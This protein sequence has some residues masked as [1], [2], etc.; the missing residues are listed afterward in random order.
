MHQHQHGPSVGFFSPLGLWAAGSNS[1][2]LLFTL[3]ENK[4]TVTCASVTVTHACVTAA[5]QTPAACVRRLM[6]LEQKFNLH[7]MLNADK[8]FLAQKSAPHRDFY[9]VRKVSGV[10]L[11]ALVFNLFESR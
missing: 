5:G 3:L 1:L 2:T 7:V 9:N 4:I 8:E 11:T 10:G 6:L